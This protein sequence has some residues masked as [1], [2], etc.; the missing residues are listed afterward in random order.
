MK[1]HSKK[2]NISH[3]YYVMGVGAIVQY[4]FPAHSWIIIPILSI[5]LGMESR[6]KF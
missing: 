4:W 5:L 1:E 3:F 6:F 2:I